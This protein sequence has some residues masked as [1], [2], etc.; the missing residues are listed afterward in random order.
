MKNRSVN[1]TLGYLYIML[2]P[3]K[4]K[5]KKS[6]TSTVKK[7]WAQS[8]DPKE[9]VRTL[10]ITTG[11]SPDVLKWREGLCQLLQAEFGEVAKRLSVKPNEE[12]A[13]IDETTPDDVDLE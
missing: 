11:A 2:Q 1:S 4:P 3:W 6:I 12:S 10:K 5:P 8:K 13:Y 9:Y 7:R